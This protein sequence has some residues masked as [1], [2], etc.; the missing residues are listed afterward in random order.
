M[1]TVCFCHYRRTVPLWPD[2]ALS[3][4]ENF[5]LQTEIWKLFVIPRLSKWP[6]G[7]GFRVCLQCSAILLTYHQLP[8]KLDHLHSRLLGVEVWSRASPGTSGL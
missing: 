3:S 8:R 2:A 6:L 4:S 7:W 1:E 5:N